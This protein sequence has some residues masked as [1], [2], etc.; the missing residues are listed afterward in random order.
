MGNKMKIVVGIGFKKAGWLLA[1]VGLMGALGCSS[2]GSDPAKPAHVEANEICP[3]ISSRI[4]GGQTMQTVDPLAKSI[5]G[6]IRFG[7]K[8]GGMLCT[9]VIISKDTIL[10]AA[11]CAVGKAKDFRIVFHTS[12]IRP[13]CPSSEVVRDVEEILVHEDYKAGAKMMKSNDIALIKLKSQIPLGYTPMKLM[14]DYTKVD[15]SSVIVAGFGV[16][17]SKQKDYGILKRTRISRLTEVERQDRI[18]SL[19]WN[20]PALVFDQ[21]HG[22]GICQGDSG[23]GAF[24]QVGDEYRLIGI[25][26]VVISTE[27]SEPC[28]QLSAHMNVRYYW[29]WIRDG[30]K[31]LHPKESKTADDEKP[32]EKSK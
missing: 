2:S 17:A 22:S 6:I 13:D 9:G 10:T 8:D 20:D 19:T 12:L 29:S 15:N 31:K 1:A 25:A 18:H 11:H 32:E 21:S 27:N 26:S 7:G 23:G 24:M 4:Y 30:I 28:S 14:S 3:L 5:V 16:S